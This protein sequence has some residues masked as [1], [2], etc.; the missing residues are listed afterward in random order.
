M[1]NWK[2]DSKQ[3]KPGAAFRDRNLENFYLGE[4]KEDKGDAV[5][6]V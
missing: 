6:Y 5:T 4:N 1:M 3:A 2:F